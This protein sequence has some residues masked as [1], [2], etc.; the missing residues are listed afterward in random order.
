MGKGKMPVPMGEDEM[1]K[2]TQET[3]YRMLMHPGESISA[4]E[5]PKEDG[6]SYSVG[7]F[8][9]TSIKPYSDNGQVWLEVRE[10]DFVCCRVPAYQVAI[11]YKKPDKVAPADPQSGDE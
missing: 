2:R 3:T 9:I 8:G 6:S 1:E 5:W 11:F 4:I 7:H 10:G